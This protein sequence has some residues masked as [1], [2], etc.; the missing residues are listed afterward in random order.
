MIIDFEIPKNTDLGK[1]QEI[2]SVSAAMLDPHTSSELDIDTIIRMCDELIDAH[3]D[4]LPE[5]I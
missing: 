1:R 4:Y 2:L 3:G 5:F